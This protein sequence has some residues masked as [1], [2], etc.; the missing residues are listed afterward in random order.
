MSDVSKYFDDE[1]KESGETHS[2][3]EDNE[4]DSPTASDREFIDETEIPDDTQL[5]SLKH[6]IIYILDT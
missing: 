2:D 6:T 5:H 4:T 1:A 3:D